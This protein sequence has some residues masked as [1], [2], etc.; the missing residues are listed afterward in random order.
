M[1]DTQIFNLMLAF[2][3]HAPVERLL[4]IH[5]IPSLLLLRSAVINKQDSA[6]DIAPLVVEIVYWS[7]LISIPYGENLSRLLN[8]S[9]S[10]GGGSA[11]SYAKELPRHPEEPTCKSL[12]PSESDADQ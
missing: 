4:T 2:L 3:P 7:A 8:G 12:F 11:G 5:L 10:K 9:V 1:A 6:L